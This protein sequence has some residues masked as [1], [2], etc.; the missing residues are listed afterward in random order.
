MTGSR[1]QAWKLVLRHQGL[2]V[3]ALPAGRA[4][5]THMH[6]LQPLLKLSHHQRHMTTQPQ[7]EPGP[8]TSFSSSSTLRHA[9]GPSRSL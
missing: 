6:F 4:D 2:P 5:S 9:T 1:W 3:A 7:E 8:G